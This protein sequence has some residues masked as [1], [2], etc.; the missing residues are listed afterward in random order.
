MTARRCSFI[1]LQKM[2][3][4]V[5]VSTTNLQAA[6]SALRYDRIIANKLNGDN[7]DD[8]IAVS[9]TGHTVS[10]FLR[11]G[12]GFDVANR[13]D[14]PVGV[15][16][17]AIVA[18]ISTAGGGFELLAADQALGTVNVVSGSFQTGATAVSYRASTSPTGVQQASN[19]LGAPGKPL[20]FD[21]AEAVATGDFNEDGIPDAIVVHRGTNSFSL[22]LGTSDG[23]WS[24]PPSFLPAASR[25][26]CKRPISI[27]TLTPIWPF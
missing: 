9:S 20:T 4:A 2:A 3:P 6:N 19:Q 1:G 7:R 24:I 18:A 25:L 17:A 21:G 15:A 11:S 16:P 27:M 22:L 14:V 23:G 13:K 10:M 12:T 8:L 5:L 26:P